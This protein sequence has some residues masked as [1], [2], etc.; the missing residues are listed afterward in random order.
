[1]DQIYKRDEAAIKSLS[2]LAYDVTQKNGTEPRFRNEFWQHKEEGI[3]VDIVSGEPL[4]ASIDKFESLSGWP[5]FRK[6]LQAENI[7]ERPDHSYGMKRTEV[8]SR[9][10]NSHLG[11]LFHDGPNPTGIRYCINSAALRFVPK[12]HLK[13]QGYEDYL[14]LFETDKEKRK[15]MENTSKIYLAGGCFWGMQ[16]LIRRQPGVLK[17]RVGYMGGDMEN[18]KY[19]DLKGGDTGHAETVEIIF[20]PLRTSLTRILEFFFQIHDPSTSNRQGNDI[21]SQYR[22]AI[23]V[24]N[25]TDA[26]TAAQIIKD[27]DASGRWPGSVKTQII[28]GKKFYEAERAHQDYLINNPGGYTCHWVRPNW[29]LP[30]NKSKAS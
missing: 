7:L 29:V 25:E 23:F 5:S 15:T 22:S 20:D 28:R 24:D 21:G 18:P 3:Y 9:H 8:R 4:F 27:V 30:T 16:D 19:T 14:I 17:T 10:G 11:H 26:Q 6:P 12:N 1:M 2:P 13:D